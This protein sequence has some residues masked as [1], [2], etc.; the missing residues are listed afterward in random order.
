MALVQR[1]PGTGVAG[2]ALDLTAVSAAPGPLRIHETVLYAS[3][4]AAA[5]R[6]YA[7]VVGLAPIAAPDEHSA[8][9]RLADGGVLLLFDPARSG[10]A[11]RVVPA[12]GATGPGHVAFAVP[13]GALEAMSAHLGGCGVAIE[14]EITWPRG[15]RSAY[16]RDP[17]GNSVEF[18]E[19]EIWPW[20]GDDAGQAP[21]GPT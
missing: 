6:F 17:A 11:G 13:A 20:P 7:E 8:G 16:V 1:A 10:A 14:R 19:G 3:D 18:V 21:D 5:R 15:G 12:H 9:F 2:G 4:V